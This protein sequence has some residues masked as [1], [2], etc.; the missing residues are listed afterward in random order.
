MPLSPTPWRVTKSE[1]G[2]KGATTVKEDRITAAILLTFLMEMASHPLR[3]LTNPLAEARLAWSHAKVAA[4]SIAHPVAGGSEILPYPLGNN[5]YEEQYIDPAS[6]TG[7]LNGGDIDLQVAPYKEVDVFRFILN[8]GATT[9]VVDLKIQ[10]SADGSS[11]ADLKDAD[12]V[13]IAITQLTATDDNKMAVIEV[14]TRGYVVRQ[15]IRTVLVM[16][17]ASTLTGITMQAYGH[18]GD[19]PVPV[20]ADRIELKTGVVAT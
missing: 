15:H 12:A 8:L 2:L 1:T 13:V 10:D 14:T 20:S 17:A 19:T 6:R 11:W 3:V 18:A 16:A 7:T 4:F 5:I 9:G